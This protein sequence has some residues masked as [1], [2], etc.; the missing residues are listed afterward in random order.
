MICG[1]HYEWQLRFGNEWQRIDNDCVIEAHYC[2]PGAKGITI[3]TNKGKVFIDF[4]KLE[5]LNAAV[6]VQ[7][8]SFLS[9]GQTEEICWYFRDNHLWC[10]YGSQSSSVM[11]SSISSKEIE[12]H[13]CQNPQGALRF[14]VG[15]T[16]Y[17]L[18]FATMTQINVI[19]GLCRNVRRRPK[20]NPNA[21]SLKKT[22][23]LTSAS[24]LQQSAGHV[25]WEF[26]GDEGQWME[27]Q[28]HICTFDSAA[29]ESQYQQNQRGQ[30]QLHT[31]SFSYTLD[32]PTMC[33]VNN[34]T[35]RKRAVRRNPVSGIQQSRS[36]NFTPVLTSAFLLQQSAGHVQWEFFGDEG[37]WMEYQ[38]HMC[39]F[40]SAAIE[41]QY[42]QNQ[43]GQLQLN[44]DRF[45]YTLDFS[46]MCQVN[47][48]TGM[49][50]AVRRNPVSGIHQSRLP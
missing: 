40:D 5:T 11:T 21:T 12:K 17:S 47:N 42:Q 10:E 39:T 38:A 43:R 29:I 37:Q 14:T 27:Y 13:F 45:S 2:Q 15:S 16:G 33:Q 26:F 49:K 18:D 3:N 19:T 22:P 50:R 6:K 31:G 36:L 1:K 4:D 32:F 20:F 23:V 48:I 30:L 35:G 8:L 24:P 25:Q 7:R 41:S 34:I 46:A 9:P 28:A 44:T